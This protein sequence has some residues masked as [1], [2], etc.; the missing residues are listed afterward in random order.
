MI[1]THLWSWITM[2]LCDLEEFE[3][4]GSPIGVELREFL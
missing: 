1:K 2:T 3:A 4:D